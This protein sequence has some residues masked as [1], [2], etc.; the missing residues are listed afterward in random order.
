[1]PITPSKFVLRHFKPL[2][3]RAGIPTGRLPDGRHGFRFHD[4][5]HSTASIMA[6]HA[7]RP[8]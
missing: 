8:G 1:M 7:E 4:M 2:C 3:A 6:A 5:R